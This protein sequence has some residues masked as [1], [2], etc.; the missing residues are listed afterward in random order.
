MGEEPPG[1]ATTGLYLHVPYCA[2][3]CSYCDFFRV[4]SGEGAPAWFETAL[5]TEAA[6]YREGPPVVLDSVYFGGGTPSLLGPGRIGGLCDALRA[7]FAWSREA[8]VTL[9]ANPETVTAEAL[10]GWREAGVNRLSLGVQS[11]QAPELEALGRRAAPDQARRAVELAASAGF[12]RLSVD[13]LLGVPGQTGE[14]LARTLDEVEAMPLDHLSAYMLDLHRGTT[15]HA[16][17]LAGETFLPGGDAVADLYDLLCDR[18][19]AA[20]FEHYEISNFA[21]PGGRSRHNLR[22]WRGEEYIGLGPSAHGCFRGVRTENPRSVERWRRALERGER[23]HE[24]VSEVTA[25][26]RR[27]NALIFGL[28][29]SDGV[30]STLLRGFLEEQGREPGPVLEPLLRHGYAELKGADRFRLTRLGFLCSNEVL[31]FL[32]PRGWSET[33]VRQGR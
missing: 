20:G 1:P 13:L 28:R 22:Y 12:P 31:G 29:L 21:R 24:R 33:T 32:L 25:R 3:L 16:R 14:S 30:P 8:E 2:A 7:L 6:L 4:V 18:L 27:E 19:A 26:E 23:P 9:E 5:E 10:A 17:V 15:L 11:L